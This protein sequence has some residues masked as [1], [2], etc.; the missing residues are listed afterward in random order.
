MI[1]K[2]DLKEIREMIREVAEEAEE[3]QDVSN[4]LYSSDAT[5]LSSDSVDD[6]IDSMLIKFENESILPEDDIAG[7]EESLRRKTLFSLLFEQPMEDDPA[8][9]T[10]DEEIEVDTD[11]SEPEGSEKISV[12]DESEPQKPPLDVDAFTKKV[13]RLALNSSV[14]LD[15]KTVIINRAMNFLRQNYDQVHVDEFEEILDT[16]FDFNLE[17]PPEIPER[18]IAVG[19]GGPGGGLGGGGGV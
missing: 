16:Q 17:G 12:T 13:A 8:D 4:T 5:R 7:L 15:I 18:P 2:L 11:I 19:A 10:P 14:L 1:R 3:G 9:E 6:Q